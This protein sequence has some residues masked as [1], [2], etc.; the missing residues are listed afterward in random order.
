MLGEA[1][2]K[3][4]EQRRHRMKPPELFDESLAKYEK[5]DHF[6]ASAQ[7]ELTSA[8]VR[9][10]NGHPGWQG[11]DPPV[12]EGEQGAQPWAQQRKLK[13]TVFKTLVDWS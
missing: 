10:A 2:W 13:A 4:F 1:Q 5:Y 9:L 8:K 11:F 3:Q 12:E 6:V 7:S